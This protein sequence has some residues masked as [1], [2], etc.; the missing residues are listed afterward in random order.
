MG[1]F[2]R[3]AVD[4]TAPAKRRRVPW[5]ALLIAAALFAGLAAYMRSLERGVVRDARINDAIGPGGKLRPIAEVAQ[6]IRSM[7]LVT[8]EVATKVTSESSS[9]S[10]RGAVNAKVEAPVRLLY[11]TDLS[12]LKASGVAFSALEGVLLVRIPT[13]ERIA[14]EV[15]TDSEQVDVTVGWMRFRSRAGEYFLG[16]ARHDLSERAR[17]MTLAPQDAEFVRKTTREQVES[18]VK[19]IVGDKT[20]VIVQFDD[21]GVVVPAAAPANAAA[22]E[23]AP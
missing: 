23:H 1:W 19:K 9:D 18:L 6:A 8:V 20:R 14:T 17:E 10:W 15:C 5:A 21:S 13:P 12:R 22:E 2:R 11:G 3:E 4:S 16:L 7:K